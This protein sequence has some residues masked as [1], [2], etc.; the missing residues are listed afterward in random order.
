MV[1]SE[2]VGVIKMSKNRLSFSVF[3]NVLQVVERAMKGRRRGCWL[4]NSSSSSIRAHTPSTIII[5]YSLV[6]PCI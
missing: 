4:E 6:S 1:S 3:L 5:V 2:T